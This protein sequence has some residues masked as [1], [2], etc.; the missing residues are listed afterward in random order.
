METEAV[1]NFMAPALDGIDQHNNCGGGLKDTPVPHTS[2]NYFPATFS[3]WPMFFLQLAGDFFAYAFGFHPWIIDEFPGD[4]LAL[5][6]VKP[7]C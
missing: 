1:V 3:T 2:R 4:F 5:Q 6:F 7:A